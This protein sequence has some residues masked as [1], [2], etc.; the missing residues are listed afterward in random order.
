MCMYRKQQEKPL[1]V[2]VRN[3]SE[4]SYT[5]HHF[6]AFL[7]AL[8]DFHSVAPSCAC[9]FASMGAVHNQQI[10]P[11]RDVVSGFERIKI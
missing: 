8:Q 4:A 11:I 9:H 2:T 7:S 5:R 6:S 10:L 3:E 1:S